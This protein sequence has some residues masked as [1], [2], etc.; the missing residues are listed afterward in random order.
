MS[1]EEVHFALRQAGFELNETPAGPCYVGTVETVSGTWKIALSEV[2]PSFVR[3]P[4]IRIQDTP[5]QLA[6][7]VPHLCG[8]G[9][10]ICYLDPDTINLNTFRPSEAVQSVLQAARRTLEDLARRDPAQILLDGEFEAYWSPVAPCYV[11]ASGTGEKVGKC[12]VR[13]KLDGSSVYE[14]VIADDSE[15]ISRWMDRRGGDENTSWSFRAH[16]FN[17]DMEPYIS[18]THTWPPQSLTEMVDWLNMISPSSASRFVSFLQSVFSKESRCLIVLRFR[19]DESIAASI[20]ADANVLASY[21]NRR[22]SLKRNVICSKR[23]IKEFQRLHVRLASEN[24]VFTRNV[25]N[26]KLPGKKIA[27]IG[28][29]NV[30][31]YTAQALFQNGG[32]SGGGTLHIYDGDTFLPENLGRHVLGAKYLDEN[33]AKALAAMLSGE[34]AFHSQSAEGFSQN[35]NPD[36]ANFS[37]YDLVI[38][39]T[40]NEAVSNA[41][42]RSFRKRNSSCMLIHAWIDGGGRAARAIFDDRTKACYCCLKTHGEPVVRERI[43]VLKEGENVDIEPSKRCGKTYQPYSSSCSL[44]AAGI[45]LRMTLDALSNSITY[46]FIQ[47][48]LSDSATRPKSSSLPPL[49]SCP[50]C[51]KK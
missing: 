45:A 41:L 48:P 46:N 6:R 22:R 47:A 9:G 44:T 16:L 12:F 51:Q 35:I 15:G 43:A 13:R 36:K 11:L 42:S 30:G 14:A 8:H 18:S 40:G 39:A 49:P 28:A 32:G 50:C 4:E 2:D 5:V 26:N 24:Y 27:V 33:K 29:G 37:D 23:T 7:N 38:D 1:A 31:S 19:N 17:V 3:L 25:P 34:S 10:R 21:G 20:S